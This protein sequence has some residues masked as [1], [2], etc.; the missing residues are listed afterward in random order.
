[1]KNPLLLSIIAIILSM[2][3]TAYDLADLNPANAAKLYWDDSTP[4]PNYANDSYP[5]GSINTCNEDLA[6]YLLDMMKGAK[7]SQP[8]CFQKKVTRCSLGRCFP[9]AECRQVWRKI[10]ACSGF[11]TITLSGMTAATLVRPATYFSTKLVTQA[12]F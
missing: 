4:L 11:W 5:D 10:K 2:T 8:P 7:G 1:M 12:I 6:K 9:M 3:K